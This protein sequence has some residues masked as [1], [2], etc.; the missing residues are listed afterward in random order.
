MNKTTLEN[1]NQLLAPYGAVI[2]TKDS[3]LQRKSEGY[4]GALWA[5][6]SKP[7]RDFQIVS[8]KDGS[9][10]ASVDSNIYKTIDENVL[11]E[12]HNSYYETNKTIYC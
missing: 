6:S 1:L 9:S 8:V 3:L 2:S 4:I 7:V 10:F 11:N 12:V 5:N